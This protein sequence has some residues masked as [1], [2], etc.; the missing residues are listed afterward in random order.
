MARVENLI[1]HEVLEYYEGS[2]LSDGTINL[3]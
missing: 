2:C 1:I 3:H